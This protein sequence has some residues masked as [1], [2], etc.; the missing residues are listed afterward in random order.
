FSGFLGL[1]K[2]EQHPETARVVTFFKAG[3]I[4]PPPPAFGGYPGFIFSVHSCEEA[5]NAY[6]QWLDDTLSVSWN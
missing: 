6:H 4:S 3:H 5:A 1:N 2:V